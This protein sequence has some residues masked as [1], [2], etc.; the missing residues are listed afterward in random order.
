MLWGMVNALTLLQG[1]EWGG[2]RAG[3]PSGDAG[4]SPDCW[5]EQH[6]DGCDCQ[7][8]TGMDSQIPQI[9]STPGPWEGWHKGVMMPLRNH[10]GIHRGCSSCLSPGTARTCEQLEVRKGL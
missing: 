7:E 10:A 6:W 3:H 8:L 5:Q 9:I 2:A 1:E 4:G